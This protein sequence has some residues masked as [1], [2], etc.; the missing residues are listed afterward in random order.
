MGLQNSREKKREERN[1]RRI[2]MPGIARDS[3]KRLLSLA[4]SGKIIC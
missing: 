3:E 4:Y 2:L 1:G